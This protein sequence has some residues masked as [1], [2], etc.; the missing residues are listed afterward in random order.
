ML[1]TRIVYLV[2]SIFNLAMNGL[3]LLHTTN[4]YSTSGDIVPVALLFNI[5]FWPVALFGA[6][7]MGGMTQEIYRSKLT[8]A[9]LATANSM[10]SDQNDIQPTKDSQQGNKEIP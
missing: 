6:Y 10:I 7:R 3:A 1:P 5:I 9:V 8:S 4:I 2:V